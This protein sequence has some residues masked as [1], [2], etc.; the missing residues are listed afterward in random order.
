MLHFSLPLI[1]SATDHRAE[2]WTFLGKSPFL[3][4]KCTETLN[5]VC[6]SF[7]RKVKWGWNTRQW[8]TKAPWMWE[9]SKCLGCE[10][11]QTSFH[12]SSS[13]CI[14]PMS[15]LSCMNS[16]TFLFMGLWVQR[17]KPQ[18]IYSGYLWSVPNSKMGNIF[19]SAQDQLR[20][21]CIFKLNTLDRLNKKLEK[22]SIN[23]LK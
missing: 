21:V 22:I 5:Q 16:N 23:K 9:I 2:Q 17:I 8:D 15:S 12:V 7:V 10:H 3:Y 19:F 20:M 18:A 4:I 14:E 11:T 13:C 1:L 6:E